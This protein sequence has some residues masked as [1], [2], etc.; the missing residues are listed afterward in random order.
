MPANLFHETDSDPIWTA[1]AA[2]LI[3]LALV[4]GLTVWLGPD[5]IS[6]SAARPAACAQLTPGECTARAEEGW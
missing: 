5:L 6:D 1:V 2:R 4:A 3:I